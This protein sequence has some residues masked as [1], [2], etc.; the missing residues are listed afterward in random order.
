MFVNTFLAIRDPNVQ[1]FVTPDTRF[2]LGILFPEKRAYVFPLAA[3]SGAHKVVK[4]SYCILSAL[5]TAAFPPN[6]TCIQAAR[7]YFTRFGYRF[8]A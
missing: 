1:S 2:S 3:T 8:C 7:T 6:C 4:G 5:I